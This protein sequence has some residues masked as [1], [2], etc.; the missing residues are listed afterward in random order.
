MLRS[1]CWIQGGMMPETAAELPEFKA[2]SLIDAV[3]QADVSLKDSAPEE[4]LQG[5][6]TTVLEKMN[7]F[8]DY[9]RTLDA[10][11]PACSEKMR[12]AISY[13]LKQE[14]KLRRFLED[15]MIPSDNGFCERHIKPFAIYRRNSLFSYSVEGAE[16]T[17]VLFSLVETAKANQAHPYYYLKFLLEQ[18]PK[19]TTTKG[20]GF[21]EG[22]MP[23]SRNYRNYEDK[24]KREALRFFADQITPEKPRTPKKHDPCA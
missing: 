8:F 15:P 6:Q 10:D 4:R 11:D 13:S 5:C 21:L 14:E 18:L 16:A 9:L 20:N 23:W 1:L 12:D 19:Q 7:A 22:F 17:A 2:L 3:I 24:E